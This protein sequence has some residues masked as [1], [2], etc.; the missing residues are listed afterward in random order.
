LH[1]VVKVDFFLPGCP[2]PSE[3]I[4][5]MLIALIKGKEINI[6]DYTRFGK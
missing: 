6:S 3:A 2:T 1:E 5:E 4:Y